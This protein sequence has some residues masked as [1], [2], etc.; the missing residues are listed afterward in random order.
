MTAI[1]IHEV[2][3]VYRR[4]SRRRK[5]ATLKSALLSRTLLRDLRV[6]EGFEALK[7][8]SFDVETGRAVGIIGRNG[9]GK[10]TLLK[11]IAGIGKP[12]MG[13]VRVNGRISALIELGAGF[14]PEISG[15][16]NI[17]IN[18]MM[19][20]LSRREV[21]SQLDAI[22]AF[23]ELEDFIDAPVK[24]YS[25]GMY[26]RLGFSVAIHVDPDILLVDEVLAVGDEA[27]THKCLD[28][29]SEFRRRGKTIVLVTH[30]LDLIERLCDEA[31]WLDQGLVKAQGNPRRV[32]D[33]YRLDVARVE[34]QQFIATKKSPPTATDDTPEDDVEAL[35]LQEVARVE[36]QQLIATKKSPLTVTDD[37]PEDDVEHETEDEAGPGRWGSREVEI[38]DVQLLGRDGQIQKVFE[39]GDQ[40]EIRLRVRPSYPMTDFA[41]GIGI[42]NAEGVSCYGTN[43]QIEGVKLGE[44]HSEA[45]V[46]FIINSLDLVA[47]TYMLD[48]AVHR[49]NGAPYDYHHHLYTCRVTSRVNDVGIFRPR[50][51]WSFTGGVKMTLGNETSQNKSEEQKTLESSDTE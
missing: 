28:K 25:S 51:R 50:H 35:V 19:L 2:R 44:L 33:A 43:T 18:G 15:R 27:F 45:D 32:V 49:Q 48:V 46:S 37:T 20:G 29:F 24:T 23:A 39:T 4:F 36:D 8:V 9:S 41:F 26:M 1:Q 5:F 42:F 21:A 17:F 22:V 16:E 14:H 11:L 13:K 40:M 10:S 31:I 7:G 6:N 12:T 47:G 30:S 3:K 34:D 38:L